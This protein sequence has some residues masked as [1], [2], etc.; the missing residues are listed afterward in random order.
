MKGSVMAIVRQADDWSELKEKVEENG[1]VI[2]VAMGVIR[3]A[4]GFQ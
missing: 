3:H 2:T 1:G 4:A